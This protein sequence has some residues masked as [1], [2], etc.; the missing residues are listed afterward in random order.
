MCWMFPKAKCILFE[1]L[2]LVLKA[3][4]SCFLVLRCIF[5][6]GMMVIEGGTVLLFYFCL[7][8]MSVRIYGRIKS[9]LHSVG[10]MYL[11]LKCSWPVNATVREPQ[12]PGPVEGCCAGSHSIWGIILVLWSRPVP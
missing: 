8:F 1:K 2:P 7:F 11:N 10:P 4:A 3:Y 6:Y 9:W 12:S 5:F